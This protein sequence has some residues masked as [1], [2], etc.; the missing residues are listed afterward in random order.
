MDRKF[1]ADEE[2][3]QPAVKGRYLGIARKLTSIQRQAI[4]IGLQNRD[5][6]DIVEIGSGKTAVFLFPLLAWIR[7]LSTVDRD[8]ASKDKYHQT[9]MLT[10]TMT[11]VIERLAR[12]Y[13]CRCSASVYVRSIVH[14]IIPKLI[15]KRTKNSN[16]QSVDVSKYLMEVYR[17]RHYELVKDYQTVDMILDVSAV[18]PYFD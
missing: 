9:V 1:D 3:E 15:L 6:I 7:S 17:L 4:P 14:H 8:F 2:R 16:K 5:V 18:Q 13:V 12:T 10:V 11:P